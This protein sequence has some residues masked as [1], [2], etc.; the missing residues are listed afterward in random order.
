MVSLP[1]PS[2]GEASTGPN[3]ARTR[4]LIA[5]E[6]S[7]DCQLLKTA[8]MRSR[9]R[10]DVV[11]CATS[12]SEILKCLS[13]FTIDVAVVNENLSD[14]PLLGF[15]ALN[16]LQAAFPSVRT[17]FMLKAAQRELVV[18]A[19]R[20]GAKGVLC[21]TEPIRILC[22]CIQTV[23]KGQIWADSNQLQFILDALIRST[24]LR[25]INSNGRF[26]LTEREDEVANLVAEGL[27]NREIAQKLSVAQHT[28]SNYL[29]RV[30]EKLGISSRVELVLYLM[31]KTRRPK[32]DPAGR[33]TFR[34][35]RKSVV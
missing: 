17:I 11:A 1:L 9:F 33:R 32:G 4:I 3:S 25:V 10:F 5:D 20:A 29:F 7:L 24:P 12:C 31:Q 14:G 8:L 26:L 18:D 19:F 13:T 23:H 16:E 28:V 34:L 27:S 15:Q 30:Y 35:D 2:L 6:T 22:K 21:G